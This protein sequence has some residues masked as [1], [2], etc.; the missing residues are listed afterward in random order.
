MF[1]KFGEV[2]VGKGGNFLLVPTFYVKNMVY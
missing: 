2:G 1:Y